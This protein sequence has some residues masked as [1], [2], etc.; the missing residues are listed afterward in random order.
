MPL[1][2]FQRLLQLLGIKP[3]KIEVAASCEEPSIVLD[4]IQRLVMISAMWGC[5]YPSDR[6]FDTIWRLTEEGHLHLI[7]AA[8]N[9][10]VSIHVEGLL[11]RHLLT[12]NPYPNELAID[13]KDGIGR[14]T[15]KRSL[16]HISRATDEDWEHLRKT[17]YNEYAGNENSI[18]LND[19]K[20][21]DLAIDWLQSGNPCMADSCSKLP[22]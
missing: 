15:L 18:F 4:P 9:A 2:N 8:S 1:P 12:H 22:E 5:C 17:F 10:S 6:E 7:D 20:F 13:F 19:L 11:V 21:I 16:W 14:L 3:L